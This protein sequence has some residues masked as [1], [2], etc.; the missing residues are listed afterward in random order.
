MSWS[1]NNVAHR[2]LWAMV[3]YFHKDELAGNFETFNQGAKWS[4]KRVLKIADNDSTEMV[5]SK[6]ES[7]ALKLDDFFVNLFHTSYEKVSGTL[8]LDEARDDAVTQMVAHLIQQ[9]KKLKDM[10]DIVDSH[11]LFKGESINV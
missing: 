10:G 3:R 1:K 8:T 4:N 6:A 9:D 11:Y 5:K 7:L 2:S